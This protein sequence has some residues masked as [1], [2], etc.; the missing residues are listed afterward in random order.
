[1]PSIHELSRFFDDYLYEQKGHLERSN[2]RALVRL[3]A[4]GDLL[5][6]IDDGYIVLTYRE[7]ASVQDD[8]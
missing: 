4:I 6:A 8:A 5:Q 3:Q 2:K 7:R 1:M